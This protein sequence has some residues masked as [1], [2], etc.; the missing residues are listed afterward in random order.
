M[1]ACACVRACLR[2]R[3]CV[4]ACVRACVRVC[5]CL[6]GMDD[7][8]SFFLNWR[9]GGG[10]AKFVYFSFFCGFCYVSFLSPPPPPPPPP[11]FPFLQ[12]FLQGGRGGGQIKWLTHVLLFCAGR[13]LFFF[14]FF[15]FLSLS[16]LSPFFQK[17]RMIRDNRQ[18]ERNNGTDSKRQGITLLLVCWDFFEIGD[19][20]RRRLL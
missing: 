11:P 13:G 16:L 17:R 5:V 8:M 6:R 12:H 7:R 2:V 19:S 15:L 10:V 4:C 1:R 3:V 18:K 20:H 9:G 14:S